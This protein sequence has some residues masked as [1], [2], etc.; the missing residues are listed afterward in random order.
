MPFR[1]VEEEEV[2]PSESKFRFVKEEKPKP[3]PI[4]LRIPGKVS[5]ELFGGAVGAIPQ[6]AETASQMQPII[7]QREEEA[8]PDYL[9]GAGL[10][11]APERGL[12]N[13]MALIGQTDFVQQ[14]LPKNLRERFKQSTG[15]RFEPQTVVERVL[16]RAAGSA[17][18]GLPFGL[19]GVV[20]GAGGLT[21]GV[22]E[23]AGVGEKGQ[24]IAELLGT[25]GGAGLRGVAKSTK[26]PVT[27]PSGLPVRKFE[28]LKKPKAVFKGT[29]QKALQ[30]TEKDFRK[31]TSDLQTK[32]NRSYKAMTEDPTFKSKISDIFG[33][34][35]KEASKLTE[36]V[37]TNNLANKLSFDMIKTRQR[38]ITRSP[39][40]ITQRKELNK[41]FKDT[42]GKEFTATKLLEQ[43]R[44]NN[45][46]LSKLY[47]Y[48]ENALENIGKRE[49]L[50][51]YNRA[52]ASTI[53]EQFPKTDFSDLFKF[54]NKRWSEIKK[55]ETVDKYLNALFSKDKVNFRQ[56][57]KALTDTKY[58]G[59]LKNALGKQGF[60]EFK[61]LNKDL[62]NK[63][64][65]LKLLKAKGYDMSD[66]SNLAVGY[67]FKPK[68]TSALVGKDFV[69]KAWRQTLANPK[70]IRQWRKGLSLFNRGHIKESLATLKVLE[71]ATR[72][73]RAEPK[74]KQKQ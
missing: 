20:G 59:R 33:T 71:K 65:G 4:G 2:T 70:Q 53:E 23:E 60:A 5:S 17:G 74:N 21:A 68:I 39:T 9:T 35:E 52:I 42:K 64:K 18:E 73:S 37:P 28:A 24:N 32:T 12:L 13:L 38:G 19:P 58:S 50:E 8:R 69:L 66:I 46:Q 16:S 11:P 7:E 36:K 14:M 1:F 3:L 43:Y 6:I 30:E 34:V 31:L 49:A 54:T 25:L 27:K 56:A 44:K 45:E 10:E 55:I 72:E 57:E 40:E 63:E 48:G 47:P 62:L 61:Q 51:S 67:L 41:F 29:A 15:E 22:A 26:V